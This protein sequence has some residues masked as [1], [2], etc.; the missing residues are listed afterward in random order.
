M[1]R[2]ALMLISFLL[3]AGC[4]REAKLRDQIAGTWMR[5]EAYEI[6]FA[7]D[8]SFVSRISRPTQHLTYQGVWKVDASD[9]VYTVTNCIAQDTTNFQAIGSVD[10]LAI[11][12][13]D[14]SDLVWSNTGQRIELKRKK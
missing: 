3:L 9:I 13:I 8:G 7:S 11:V 12:R 10:R 5:D 14:H 4:H 1:T 6:T 2:S